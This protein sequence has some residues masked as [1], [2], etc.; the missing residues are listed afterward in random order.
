MRSKKSSINFQKCAKTSEI[1]LGNKNYA[2]NKLIRNFQ[3]IALI[4]KESANS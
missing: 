3:Q 4:T 2:L 1:M